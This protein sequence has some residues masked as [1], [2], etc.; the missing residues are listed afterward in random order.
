MRRYARPGQL[1]IREI[2]VRAFSSMCCLEEGACFSSSLASGKRVCTRAACR[3]WRGSPA[4]GGS[5][6]AG[7][8]RLAG[9]RLKGTGTGGHRWA[10]SRWAQVRGTRPGEGEG[11]G[12]GGRSTCSSCAAPLM[13]PSEKSSVSSETSRRSPEI[14]RDARGGRRGEMGEMRGEDRRQG[15]TEK[16]E[17][18]SRT[19]KSPGCSIL[20]SR[21]SLNFWRFSDA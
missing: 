14:R 18:E 7:P 13:R 1:I 3:L 10:K 4:G 8:R 21:R 12:E 2:P 5:D 9:Q 17:R 20:L 16:R 6:A 15:E 11:G 19:G